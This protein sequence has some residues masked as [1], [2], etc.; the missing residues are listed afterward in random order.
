MREL[1][2]RLFNGKARKVEQGK[3]QGKEKH[4]GLFKDSN[5]PPHMVSSQLNAFCK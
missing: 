4:G 2:Q 1:R 5:C 3:P